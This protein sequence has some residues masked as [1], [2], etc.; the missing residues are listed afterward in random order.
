MKYFLEAGVENSP[1]ISGTHFRV[2][3]SSA[4]IKVSFYGGKLK[5][6]VT[7]ERGMSFTPLGGFTSVTM[8]SDVDQVVEVESTNGVI[9]DNRI[10]GRV[11]V[12]IEALAGIATERKPLNDIV[13]LIAQPNAG[14]NRLQIKNT[15]AEIAYIGG[16]DADSK[17]YELKPGEDFEIKRSGGAELYAVSTLTGTTLHLFSEMDTAQ[18]VSIPNNTLTTESGANLLTESGEYLTA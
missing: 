5:Q 14:R 13:T 4:P 18:A 7:L 1:S 17:G 16:L 8:K 10:A 2:T 3:E 15:G 11:S 9:D 12:V 6:D